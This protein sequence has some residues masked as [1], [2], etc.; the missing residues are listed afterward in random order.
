MLSEPRCP[1]AGEDDRS[2]HRG[3]C[4]C[5]QHR[6]QTLPTQVRAGAAAMKAAAQTTTTCNC[7]FQIRRPQPRPMTQKPWR[8]RVVAVAVDVEGGEEVRDTQRAPGK[9][10]CLLRLFTSPTPSQGGKHEP[11]PLRGTGE[12]SDVLR[13]NRRCS[14]CGRPGKP[15]P[16]NPWWFSG[17]NGLVARS[18]MR[19][20]LYLFFLVVLSLE[21]CF[22]G[23][24]RRLRLMLL[25]V[26]LNS[27]GSEWDD[28]LMVINAPIDMYAKC[29]ATYVALVMFDCIVPTDRNVIT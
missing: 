11:L 18:Q 16:T 26:F 28:D 1:P 9:A 23:W 20:P 8:E 7:H 6:R 4:S 12:H 17:K 15:E 25:N 2:H 5:Q 14:S 13:L 22:M 3:S 24:R 19:L 21:H 29:E 10:Y 27:E